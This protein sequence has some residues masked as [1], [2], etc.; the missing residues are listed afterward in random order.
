MEWWDLN[1]VH[2]NVAASMITAPDAD[3]YNLGLFLNL[4]A[5]P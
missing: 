5:R 4:K 1:P 2:V 3:F